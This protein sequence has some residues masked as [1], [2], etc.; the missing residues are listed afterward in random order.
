MSLYWGVFKN[1]QF[2]SLLSTTRE[3]SASPIELVV[4]LLISFLINE[5]GS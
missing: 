2:G 3:A 5:I 4:I 1:G